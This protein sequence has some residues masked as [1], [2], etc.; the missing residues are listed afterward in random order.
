MDVDAIAPLVDGK[1]MSA[2]VRAVKPGKA[3]IGTA[4]LNVL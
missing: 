1:F 3:V 2:F 4:A